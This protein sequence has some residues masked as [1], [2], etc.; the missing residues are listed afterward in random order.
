MPGTPMQHECNKRDKIQMTQESE[1]ALLYGVAAIA[2]FLGLETKAAR[3]HVE[4]GIIPTFKM[5]GSRMVCARPA[6]LRQWL[7]DQER[8]GARGGAAQ[9]K[10][11]S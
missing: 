8:D 6:T 2:K 9:P 10:V 4:N 1:P 5:K 7:A 11:A 3:H